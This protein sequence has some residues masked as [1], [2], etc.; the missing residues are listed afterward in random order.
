MVADPTAPDR[1]RW[2]MF[3]GQSGHAAS[4]HYDD[5]Q[6][7]WLEVRTPPMCGEG[8]WL[9]LEL[10]SGGEGGVARC[11][12]GAVPTSRPRHMITE[13]EPVKAALDE[14]RELQGGEKVEFADLVIRGAEDKARELRAEGEPARRARRDVAAWIRAGSGPAADLEAAEEVKHLGLVANFDE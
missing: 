1:S 3:A 13:T 2:Q 10:V 5:L 4:P 14:L 7:D 12:T 9:E 11:Y 8:P 6:A